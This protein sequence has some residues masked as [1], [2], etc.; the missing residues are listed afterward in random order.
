MT[1]KVI[2]EGIKN[3]REKGSGVYREGPHMLPAISLMIAGG[4]LKS[5]KKLNCFDT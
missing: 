4:A 1:E 2:N 3:V 5:A